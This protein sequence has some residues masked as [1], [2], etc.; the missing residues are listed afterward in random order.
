M[1]LLQ[2]RISALIKRGMIYLISDNP[3]C[4]KQMI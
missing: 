3:L 2:K 4:R 1:Y